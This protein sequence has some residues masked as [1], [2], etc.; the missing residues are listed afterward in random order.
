MLITG[1]GGGL[2]S[3]AARVFAERGWQ[4]FA[5]DLVPPEP[6]P[7]Q[8]PLTLDVT[9]TASVSAA[10]DTVAA[11]VPDG[12]GCVV[13]FAGVLGVGPLV[14][15]EEDLL[16]RVLDVN[17]LGTYR[18]NKAAFPLLRAGGGRILNISSEVGWQRALPLNGPYAMSKHAIEA[19]SDALRRELMFVG[20]PV[21]VIQP[22]PFR[23][24]LTGGAAKALNAAVRPGSP[25]EALTA[26]T[27]RLAG[28]AAAGADPAELT[29]VIWTAATTARPRRRYSVRPDRGRRFLHH[30]PTPVADAMLRRTL[31]G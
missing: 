4:V 28:R 20:V 31:G 3:A 5:A 19:Y 26:R 12:L 21:V 27:A 2:G 24:E 10:I 8:T 17:V 16:R 25:F 6:A 1:A 7:N 11:G 9:S 15:I 22:G 29:E 30:L 23:T 13:N 14:E 18:V